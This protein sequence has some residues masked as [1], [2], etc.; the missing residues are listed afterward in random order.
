MTV[1]DPNDHAPGPWGAHTLDDGE[2]LDL[3]IGPVSL[4]LVR[5]GDEIRLTQ[6]REGDG[7]D[8]DEVWDRWAT[9]DWTGRLVLSPSFPDR[10]VVVEPEDHF[11]LLEDAEA[12][13]YVRVP[14]WVTIEAEGARDRTRLVTIPTVLS[15]DTWWGSVEEGELCY[16]LQTHA[17][18][19]VTPDLFAAHLAICPLQLQN[20]APADLV[21]AK[22]ALRVSY[23]TLYSHDGAIWSD[24]TRVRYQ[25][26]TE[27]SR[28]DMAGKP[29]REV[30]DAVLLA[31]PR[32]RMSRGFR[33]RTFHRLRSLQPWL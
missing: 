15:S 5:A 27:D 13:I 11:H 9:A 31:P 12:R 17:R 20:R 14:L 7:A 32:T 26:E 18:R 10:P 8:E 30:P 6:T 25:G 4:R 21:V 19:S 22:I 3:D 29:P 28:L 24:E 1:P 16:W 23:L 2:T 33:A